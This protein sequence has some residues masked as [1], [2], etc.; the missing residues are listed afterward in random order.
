MLFLGWR[1]EDKEEYI[2]LV[3]VGTRH[4]KVAQGWKRGGPTYTSIPSTKL[5]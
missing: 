1:G 4:A 3:E 2:C 5:P